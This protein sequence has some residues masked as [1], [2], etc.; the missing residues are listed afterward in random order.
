MAGG[1]NSYRVSA[2]FDDRLATDSIFIEAHKRFP[3]SAQRR[4]EWVRSL[5]MLGFTRS[6]AGVVDV[7]AE[8][9]APRSSQESVR[10][11]EVRPP[12]EDF[13]EGDGGEAFDGLA[14]MLG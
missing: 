5:I 7:K 9:V 10:V 6:E 11:A 4:A 3:G 2:F 1:D 13:G 8:P 12:A 14:R